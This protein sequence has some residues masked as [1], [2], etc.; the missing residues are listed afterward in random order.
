LPAQLDDQI[1]QRYCRNYQ[2]N[3]VAN[4]ITVWT[5]PHHRYNH[6]LSIYID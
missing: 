5:A 1:N 3:R 4:S 6:R 2:R